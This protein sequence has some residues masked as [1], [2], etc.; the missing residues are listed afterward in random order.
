M[1]ALPIAQAPEALEPVSVGLKFGF[2]AI[3]YLFLLWVVRSS[4]RDLRG[5]GKKGKGGAAPVVA[6][7]DATGMH[8][9]VDLATAGQQGSAFDPRLRV[10]RG[11]GLTAGDEYEL[12][13]G[14]T[15]GRGAQ[16][17]IR[18]ED[19][20]ASSRHAR[21]ERQGSFMVIEDLGSTN[22]T[23]LNE[24]PLNGPQPLHENDRVRIGDT[25]FVYLQ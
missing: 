16:A 25:E 1:I 19:A 13:E 8:K 20:F 24:Q 3:L 6:P 23:Y 22:G 5:K 11:A 15:L 21:C 18:L 2:L 7:R 4:V 17:E 10:E 14:A 9:A 12:L